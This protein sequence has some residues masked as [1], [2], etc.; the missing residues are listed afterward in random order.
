[1]ELIVAVNLLQALLVV[2]VLVFL[3]RQLRS[4]ALDHWSIAWLAVCG[5]YGVLFIEQVRGPSTLL[6]TL[7]LV[8]PPHHCGTRTAR[9]R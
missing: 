5:R 7:E 6:G 3:R 9:R 1:M 4:R 8:S 2:G